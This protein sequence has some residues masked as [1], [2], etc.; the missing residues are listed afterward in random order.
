MIDIQSG[1]IHVT[2]RNDTSMTFER[3]IGGNFVCD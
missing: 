2:Y 1:M 3:S